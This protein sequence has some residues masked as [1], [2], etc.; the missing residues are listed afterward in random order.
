MDHMKAGRLIACLAVV[1]TG[2]LIAAGPATGPHPASPG[3]PGEGKEGASANGPAA[4][5]ALRGQIDE[6]N[7]DA[8]ERNF[9]SARAAGAKTIILQIDTYGGLVTAGLDISRFLKNQRDL[10]TIAFVDT[11][12]ISAGAMIA[13]ACDEIVMAGDAVIGDCAP[14]AVTETGQ[15]QA[16]PPAERAKMESPILA[17][18]DDSAARNGHDVLLAEAMVAVGR[19]VHWVQSDKGERRFVNHQDYEK[20]TGE[21]WRP[22][23]G[24]PDPVDP[25]DR[26][27]TLHTPMAI[28][29]GLANGQMPSAA[30][31]ARARDL[32]IA[33]IYEPSVGDQIV[34]MLSGNFARFILLTIF[35]QSLYI[36]LHTPGH[37]AAEA[38]AVVSLGLLVGI[39]LLT[40]YATWWE[41]A[42]IFC[43]LAL[44]AFEIFVFPGHLV[45][46]VIGALMVI[47]GLVLTFVG[48][49]PGG[50]HVWPSMTSTWTALSNGLMVVTAGLACSLFLWIWLNRYLPKLPYFNRLILTS[51]TGVLSTSP[52]RGPELM[53]G[54]GD[55]GVAVTDLRPS[56]SAKFVS[57]AFPDGRIA[58]VISESGFVG[59][60]TNVQVREVAGNRVVVRAV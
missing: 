25:E 50:R 37:G 29:L 22:V 43:G 8:L 45:S 49:E 44:L 19:V 57:E 36:A 32:T 59:E 35:L 5:I 30:D 2:A 34:E 14:I 16:L 31:L 13:M 7:R 15:L 28:K 41:L 10:H 60:G 53:L 18:F 21:G 52:V 11:K 4:V 23:E 54:I 58:A 27:L 1:L 48:K 38:V 55:K 12:A 26:L 56:G 17:D 40:G 6:Y 47:G 42:V 3:V 9:K 39:P 51:T 24:V 46:G 20:L 33:A